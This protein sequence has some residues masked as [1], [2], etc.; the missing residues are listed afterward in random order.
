MSHQIQE[1]LE[2]FGY[3][4][5]TNTFISFVIVMA[6]I[7]FI[8]WFAHILTR[9]ILLNVFRKIVERS[10]NQWDDFLLS[11]KFFTKLGH[12]VPGVTIYSFSSMLPVGQDI[13]TRLSLVYISL[14]S[15]AAL[16]SAINAANDVY[17]TFKIS[18]KRPIK[19]YL[20]IFKILITIITFIFIISI[21]IDKSPWGLLASLGGMTA[22]FLLIFKDS[23]L[24]L[25]AG[26]Q[27]SGEDMVR[28]G[29][30]IEVPKYN[31]DGDVLE[32]S[33]NTIKVRNFDKTISTIPTYALISN[34]FKNWRG[35]TEARLR[36]IKRSVS[37][38]ANTIKFITREELEQWEKR[39][40][41][42]TFLKELD[43]LHPDLS[44]RLKQNDCTNLSLFRK[45][46]EYYLRHHEDISKEAILMVRELTPTPE[47]LP[48]QI[49][50]F[51]KDTNWVNYENIQAD[52]FDY[53]V[54]II[55]YFD[56]K[57]FQR[58]SGTD[59]SAITTKI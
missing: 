24:G 30:W 58:P 5:A 45:F 57:V 50:I 26:I 2:Q 8:A 1:Y 4:P 11:N 34:S 10:K 21:L 55:P 33:L 13:V 52:I 53:I 3:S 28:V 14:M 48:I 38:D 49:Y 41:L 20:Q 59:F 46:L 40:I 54:A 23:I 15:I 25:V 19:G 39:P 17:N 29:D 9:K 32:I 47:G 51:S 35:M 31:V 16:N 44:E 22:I 12:L 7:L 27:L 36:R 37:I 6:T 43:N 18:R 42:N 56:L